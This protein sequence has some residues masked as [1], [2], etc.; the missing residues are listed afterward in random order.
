MILVL[1]MNAFAAF[2]LVATK[3]LL[4]Y[5]HPLLMISIRLLGASFLI[6]LYRFFSEK[7]SPPLSS[8]YITAL[9]VIGILNSYSVN[10][11]QLIGLSYIPTVHASLWYNSTPF[12]VALLNFMVYRVKISY[13]KLFAILLGW[14]G[15]I[16]LLWAIPPSSLSSYLYGAGCFLAAA[17]I[18]GI[19]SLI[20]EKNKVIAYYPMSLTNALGMA[21]GGLSALAHYLIFSPHYQNLFALGSTQQALL[22]LLIPATLIS[23]VFYFYFIRKYGS[24]VVT[25]AG[26]SL[27]IFSA[28][29]EYLWTG[30]AQ[31]NASLIFST[32]LISSAL[33]LFTRK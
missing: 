31:L 30:N 7:T 17:V 25:F 16:P 24:L 15:F 18:T 21:I 8:S 13:R 10:L 32:I 12:V 3:P 26:F 6:F 19:S 4:P 2:I 22:V 28:L 5:V 1:L 9:L 33:F 29:F 20:L 27:P 11:L 14:F 23:A